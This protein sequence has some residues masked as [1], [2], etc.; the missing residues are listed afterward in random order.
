MRQGNW[1]SD[2]S[3]EIVGEAQGDNRRTVQG[4]AKL[5]GRVGKV[6]VPAESRADVSA[7]GFWKQGTTAMSDIRIFNLDAGSYLHMIP[8][9]ALAKS[10]KEEKEFYLQACL[11]HRRN[12][13]P[14]IYSTDRIPRAEDLTAQRALAALLS[15]KLKQEYSE[16]CGFVR[17]RMSLAIVRSNILLLRVPQEKGLRTRH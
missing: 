8:E 2:G 5:A 14:M 3:A 4:E 10:E 13:T 12:F 1:T 16:M 15:Y 6:Q 9:N 7:Q 11:E 17:A